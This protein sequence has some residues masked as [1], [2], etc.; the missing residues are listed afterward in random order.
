[1]DCEAGRMRGVGGNLS[2]QGGA[3]TP[4]PGLCETHLLPQ[5][6]KDR[7]R[8]TL[9]RSINRRRPPS[10]QSAAWPLT[11]A[12]FLY[13]IRSEFTAASITARLAA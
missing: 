9:G 7:S 1:V 6:E 13:F 11:G 5:G 8:P 10:I 2:G 4:H 12:P 3:C